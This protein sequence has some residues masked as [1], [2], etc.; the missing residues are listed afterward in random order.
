MNRIILCLALGLACGAAGADETAADDSGLS[1][2]D[3]VAACAA[4]HGENGAKPIRPEY[5]IL[6]GQYADYLANAMRA[7]R[8]G[9]RQN[10]IMSMQFEA[11]E[12]SDRDIDRLATHFSNHAGVR[13]LAD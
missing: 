11:L 9:R 2:E 1:F 10:P 6:A 13:S 7:Y 8:D 12:L 5:P 4:C 3:K